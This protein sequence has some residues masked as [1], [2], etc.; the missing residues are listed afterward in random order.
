[1]TVWSVC[2]SLSISLLL[3]TGFERYSL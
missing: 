1:L 3:G 2:L